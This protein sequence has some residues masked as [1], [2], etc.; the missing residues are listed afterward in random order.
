MN[1]LFKNIIIV[2]FIAIVPLVY[3]HCDFNDMKSKATIGQM[4]IVVDENLQPLT[5]QLINDFQRLNPE[6]KVNVIFKPTKN[7]IADLFNKDT[8]L[9]IIAGDLNPDDKKFADSNKIELQRFEIG[10]DGIGFIVNPDNPAERLTS[11]DI[12][13]IFT[14]QYT[15]WTQ[16]KAQDDEQNT[17]VK[18]LMKGSLDKI[19]VYI[20][21]PNSNTYNYVKDSVLYGLNYIKSA[22]I[23]S[24]SVQM[25]EEIRGNKNA[26]GIINM[27]WLSK[28]S[29][30]LM[31]TTVKTIRVSKIW[32]NGRQDDFAQFHQ[33]LIFTKKYPYSRKIVLYSRDFG[34]QLS[35]GFIT[36]LVHNDG[37]KIVLDNG[38]VPINQPIRT[39]QIE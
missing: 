37:Q 13:K 38:L 9:I 33:G 8:K 16:I 7:T 28:G 14:G 19:K 17:N 29:Q 31:D 20:Q 30:D 11:D 23:C 36:Y 39:I 10:I 3:F 34:I 27:S 26:I 21:R 15:D 22:E 6:A 5:L 18:N 32:P 4:T 25:L 12:Q 35:T 24:T 1:N 2:L